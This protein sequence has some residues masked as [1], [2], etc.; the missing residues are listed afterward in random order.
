[1]ITAT[2][3]GA[4]FMID[5]SETETR[6]D[7]VTPAAATG[8]ALTTTPRTSAEIGDT[9]TVTAALVDGGGTEL[10]DVS[11]RLTLTSSVP[12]DV[13]VGNTVTFPSASPHVITA[14]YGGHSVSFTVEVTGAASP[15]LPPTGGTEPLPVIAGAGLLL[16]LGGAL[17]AVTQ[18][19]RAPRG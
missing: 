12:S 4:D 1:M 10:A 18:R 3:V 2:G 11:S 15:A 5:L 17:L 9:V 19:R 13:I 6:I 16:L 14:S 8:L 7:F